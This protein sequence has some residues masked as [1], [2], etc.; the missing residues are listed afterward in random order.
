ML[1]LRHSYFSQDLAVNCFIQKELWNLLCTFHEHVASFQMTAGQLFQLYQ[2]N[3]YLYIYL[4]CTWTLP[5]PHLWATAC[6]RCPLQD[7][8]SGC[9]MEPSVSLTE[10][11]VVVFLP[12]M[13]TL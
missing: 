1:A 8:V 6:G 10:F 11:S 3:S 7:S 2:Q 13:L 4:R 9:A 12:F 5:F